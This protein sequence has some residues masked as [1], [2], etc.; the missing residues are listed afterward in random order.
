MPPGAFLLL[1]SLRVQ[2]S[3]NP[4]RHHCQ[5]PYRASQLDG[6][7][8]VVILP[9]DTMGCDDE[10]QRYIIEHGPEMTALTLMLN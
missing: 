5:N 8:L 10:I 2:A 7:Q 6:N 4:C 9:C 3:D 1:Y